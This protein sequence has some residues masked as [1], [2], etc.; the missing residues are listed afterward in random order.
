M[1]DDINESQTSANDRMTFMIRNI[2]LYTA[3]LLITSKSENGIVYANKK[4]S[5]SFF[6]VGREP[7][8]SQKNNFLNIYTELLIHQ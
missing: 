2:H 8:T 1:S 6:S 3:S 7:K 4:Q 5:Q